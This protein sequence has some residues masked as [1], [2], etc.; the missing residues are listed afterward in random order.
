MSTTAIGLV[1][2][3]P[4]AIGWIAGR[5]FERAAR[6]W[7]D[8]SAHKGQTPVLLA[9]ARSLTSSAVWV[10]VFAAVIVGFGLYV[11]VIARP[12]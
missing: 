2:L 11:L 1:A 12:H 6:G 10:V 3:V 9:A 5:R 8:Y 7:S 4:L